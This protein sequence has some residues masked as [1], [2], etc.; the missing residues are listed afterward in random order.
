MSKPVEHRRGPRPDPPDAG[1][2]VRSRLARLL[3]SG[4]LERIVPHLAPETLH[5]VI[6]YRGLD[7][8]GDILSALTPAQLASVLDLDLWQPAGPAGDDRFDPGRF[9]EWIE[10]LVEAGEAAA[11]EAVA[12]IDE[13]LVVAGLSRYVRV[14][15]PAALSLP[16]PAADGS[17]D[18]V[19]GSTS[20]FTVEIGGY[21][22]RARAADSWDAIVALLVALDHDHPDRFHALMRGCRSLSNSRPER[23]GLDDLL[24]AAGQLLHD[25][26]AERTDRR[27]RQGY[28]A[29]AEARA[30]LD[31]SRDGPV[32]SSPAN[33]IAAAC[34]DVPDGAGVGADLVSETNTAAPPPTPDVRE[35]IG[36][37][38]DLLAEA[39]LVPARPRALLEAPE[40]PSPR[41]ARL[42]GLMAYLRDADEPA[43]LARGRELAFL[44]NALMAGCSIQQR[45]FTVAEASDAGVA[46]CELG[47]EHWPARW[48]DREDRDAARQA[49]SGAPLAD[50]FLES[51]DLVTAF[52]VGWAVLHETSMFAA[53]RLAAVLA[54]LRCADRET[55]LGLHLL[56]VELEKQRGRRTPWRARDALD[57]IATLDMLAWTALLG[58]L[59]ECPVMPDA[60]TA[61]IEG[62]TGSVSATAFEFI[63]SAGQIRQ[64]RAFL[65][66]LP[67][68]LMS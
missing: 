18:G 64:A 11:A 34:L 44:A 25:V 63:S 30:F 50:G 37:L 42:R 60:L 54:D 51:H 55:Q 56:R 5:Q 61:V 47:L 15:D 53:G 32:A 1:S 28:L 35:S 59:D 23:D 40:G 21:A 31:M 26:A 16:S 4:A 66:R 7:A 49:G 43:F 10:N 65:D 67:A 2:S 9:G 33:P 13:R 58:L 6:R 62:R 46:A 8:S 17:A 14:F 52:Q 57:V 48:P 27:A 38:T 22:V 68:I 29:P 41:A 39:G 3:D 24:P 19:G 12:R 36:A 20:G 45:P